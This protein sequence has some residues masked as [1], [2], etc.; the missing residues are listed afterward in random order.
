MR[1]EDAVPSEISHTQRAGDHMTPLT[2]GTQGRQADRQEVTR[3]EGGGSL[4][5]K[6]LFGT[7]KKF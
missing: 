4:R 2:R 3:G 6:F 5:A 1:P 7:M